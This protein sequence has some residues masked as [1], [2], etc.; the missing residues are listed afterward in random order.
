MRLKKFIL[1]TFY[2]ETMK[3]Q[4][5]LSLMSNGL[6]PSPRGTDTSNTLTPSGIDGSLAGGGAGISH[7]FVLCRAEKSFRK[8]FA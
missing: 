1:V 2:G 3:M 8:K 5:H 7:N 4:H 6:Y